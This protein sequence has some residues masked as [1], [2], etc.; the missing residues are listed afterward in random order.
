MNVL[1]L[2]TDEVKDTAKPRT[3]VMMLVSYNTETNTIKMISFARDIWITNLTSKT[4]QRLNAASRYGGYGLTI[5]TINEKFDLDIQNYV[6]LDFWEFTDIIDYLGG[7]DMELNVEEIDFIN[8]AASTLN[9][10]NLE[11]TEGMH[12]LN[13][14]QALYHVRNRYVKTTDENGVLV[15]GDPARS[16][17]QRKVIKLAFDKLKKANISQIT[18]VFNKA[19]SIVETN[20]QPTDILTLGLKVLANNDL[21]FEDAVSV[22]FEGM[23]TWHTGGTYLP[24][25]KKCAAKIN[26]ILYGYAEDTSASVVPTLSPAP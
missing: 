20:M 8:K 19:L 24:N 11:R 16:V 9:V 25:F 3:D 26:D 6:Q 17:R 18:S 12:H 21:K 14:I 10:A 2:G 13:G 7:L 22:P 4:S 15:N 23:Y 1:V 5:N